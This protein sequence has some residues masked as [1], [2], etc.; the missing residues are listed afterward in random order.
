MC[1][2]PAGSKQVKAG[3]GRAH[4]TLQHM[5][6]EPPTNSRDSL[7][8][9]VSRVLSPASQEGS[10]GGLQPDGDASKPSPQH[11]RNSKKKS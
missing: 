3:G 9:V 5:Q 11:R 10:E 1:S 2:G 8:K 6:N 7:L 4:G